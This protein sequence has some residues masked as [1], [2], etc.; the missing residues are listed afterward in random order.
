MTVGFL[1]TRSGE[2]IVEIPEACK[3][4]FFLA[5]H[6][7]IGA[8]PGMRRAAN[9]I[10]GEPSSVRSPVRRPQPGRS[11]MLKV[12]LPPLGMLVFKPA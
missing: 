11:H 6:S 4:S 1:K 9:K 10:R 8:L 2:G 7:D 5:A 12:T 3:G